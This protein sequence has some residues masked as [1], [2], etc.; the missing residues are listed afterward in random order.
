MALLQWNCNSYSVHLAELRQLISSFSATI[1]C[2]QESRFRPGHETTMRH[3]KLFSKDRVDGAVAAGG[4]CTLVHSSLFS[5]EVPLRTQLEAVAVRTSL[6]VM[7]TVCNV[8]IPPDS[9][10]DYDQLVD[11]VSQLPPPFLLLGDVNAHNTIWGSATTSGKGRDFER[12]IRRLDLCLL[13][14]GEPTHFSIAHGTYSSIDI[15]LCSRALVPLLQWGVHDDLC[16]SDHFPIIVTLPNQRAIE[17]PSRWLLRRADWPTFTAR[18]VFAED[19][20]ESVDDH[21]IHITNGILA[22]AEE[23]IPSS[24]GNSRRKLVPWWTAEIAAAIK[25]RRRAFKCYRRQNTMAN[26]ITFRRMRA[27]ARYLIRESKKTTWEKYVSSMTAHT[28]SSQVW[29]KLRRISG[30]P[31]SLSIPG[32]SINGDIIT[33]HLAIANSIGS[34]FSDVSCSG[35]YDPTFLTLKR[36]AETHP[37]S[38]ATAASESYNVPFSEWELRSALALCRDTAPGPD[39][40]HNQMLKHLCESSIKN[41]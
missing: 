21:T 16:N 22:A 27:R 18:A 35:S 12:L 25:D 31:T 11:L 2:L 40:I 34:H 28:P 37:L 26:L 13:N 10:P 19:T 7:A 20:F 36:E 15:T 5:E 6:P 33:D 8:Y 29:T 3:F 23:T 14:T 32:V 1:V 17:L 39:N 38:F 30:L 24:S 41:C 4:V 9:Q